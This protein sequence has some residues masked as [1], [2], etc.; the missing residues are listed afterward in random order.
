METKG[1]AGTR[2]RSVV[3]ASALTLV[4]YSILS[5]AA[6]PAHAVVNSEVSVT[7]DVITYL[8]G[9]GEANVVSVAGTG[10]NYTV[11]DTQGNTASRTRSVDTSCPGR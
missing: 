10:T 4:L 9:D 5:L 11:T 3:G 7:D 6:L 2:A 1:R 8:A